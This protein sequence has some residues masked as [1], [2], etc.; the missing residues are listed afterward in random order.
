MYISISA[1]GYA[2]S[3]LN[4]CPACG[5]RGWPHLTSGDGRMKCHDCGLVCY[6][7]EAD[8]SHY[9]R[10]DMDNDGYNEHE[11]ILIF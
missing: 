8:D 11:N 1:K 4:Y 5:S 3:D 9:C 2:P 6:I 10:D 7:V